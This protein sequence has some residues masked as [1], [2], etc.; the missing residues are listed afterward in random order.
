MPR[1]VWHPVQ[2]SKGFA[3]RIWAP[4]AFDAGGAASNPSGCRYSIQYVRFGL[5]AIGIVTAYVVPPLFSSTS[6]LYCWKP[7]PCVLTDVDGIQPSFTFC[8]ELKCIALMLPMT[9]KGSPYSLE[10]QD[11]PI[12][13]PPAQVRLAA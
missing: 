7:A 13:A 4:L 9:S 1:K 6:R 2:V 11:P 8:A 12:D 10:L 3:T 5:A